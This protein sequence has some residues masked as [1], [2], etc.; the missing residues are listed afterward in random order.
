MAKSGLWVS[1][2]CGLVIAA[3][4]TLNVCLFKE[5][6]KKDSQTPK[7]TC[8]A[9]RNKKEG[10]KEIKAPPVS[11]AKKEKNVV[12]DLILKSAYYNSW[13]ECIE[14]DFSGNFAI[15]LP[16]NQNWLTLEPAVNVTVRQQS[17]GKLS[18]K[19]NFTAEKYKIKIAKGLENKE[20]AKLA[21]N[22]EADVV[23]TPKEPTFNF[24]SDGMIFPV[25]RTKPMLPM[26]VCNVKELHVALYS[27][28]DNNLVLGS[29]DVQNFRTARKI[30]QKVYKLDLKRNK[31]YYY[32]INL[33]Q[34]MEK[35]EPGLYG[36]SVRKAADDYEY[37]DYYT[38]TRFFAVTDL[39]IQAVIDENGKKVFAAVNSLQT[40][41][42]V[43]G[44]SVSLYSQKNQLLAK[45]TTDARGIVNLDYSRS[46]AGKDSGDAPKLLIA[47]HGKDVSFFYC[48]YNGY[49]SL[50]VFDDNGHT[51][52]TS[53][54]AFVFTE[55]GVYRPGEKV[56]VSAWIRNKDFSVYKNTPCSLIL[57]DSR[58]NVLFTRKMKT[59]AQGLA[60]VD[61]KLPADIPSGN[62]YF[63]CKTDDTDQNQ[64]G[65]TSFVVADFV[66]DRIK[67]QITPSVVEVKA[68]Q[69]VEFKIAADYYFGKKV[70][71]AYWK[72]TVESA[73]SPKQ[74]AWKGWTVGTKDSFKHAYYSDSGNIKDGVA[75]VKYPGFKQRGGRSSAPVTLSVS[76]QVNEHG[77][78]AV[79]AKSSVIYHPFDWYFGF[80]KNERAALPG[81]VVFDWKLFPAVKDMKI[82]AAK[83]D[84]KVVLLK[85]DWDYVLKKNGSSYRH[86][87]VENSTEVK[88]PGSFSSNAAE[89]V[90]KMKL[91]SGSYD[92]QI[93]VDGRTARTSF[94]HY[95]GEGG[96][97]SANPS[98]LSFKTDKTEYR[99][100]DTAAVTFV[101][102][103]SGSAFVTVGDYTL[104]ESYR[105]AVKAGENTLQIP[106]GILKDT[107]SVYIGVTVAG[108]KHRLFGLLCLAVK[109]DQR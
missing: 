30:S 64:L 60:V 101:S 90:W 99:S 13:D 43:A 17:V 81:E 72:F 50:S 100:G 21:F 104:R 63:I 66:A 70:D 80:R 88:N 10:S 83:R 53:P 62:F 93:T 89:G 14:L 23:I 86:V 59:S 26:E 22:A 36:I 85:K 77:G 25:Q 67:V 9:V 76:A 102:P 6:R 58:G 31:K 19:G 96:V 108:L 28:Y 103:V 56:H 45:G 57:E 52:S 94:Y 68:D 15:V 41:K 69:N 49:H 51:Y 61:F 38:K 33:D 40:T 20:G 4:V 65:R 79:T 8:V 12:R 47:K 24:L 3:S 92:L 73:F 107:S 71:N 16:Q 78:R 105:F 32:P 27:F 95:Y 98:L 44:T 106:L 48:S 82:P 91:D 87:W 75:N 97:R 2:A 84:F 29:S 74:P 18:L 109:Q 35:W 11:V 46:V 55:R 5:L 1:L 54:R 37:S 42:P 7:S 34:L 39:A